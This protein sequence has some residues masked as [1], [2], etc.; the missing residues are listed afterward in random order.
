MAPQQP[1]EDQTEYAEAEQDMNGRLSR[2]IRKGTKR[3]GWKYVD[4]ICKMSLGYKL[5]FAWFIL[6]NKEAK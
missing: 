3:A 5:R 2:A 4:E 6:T 1:E